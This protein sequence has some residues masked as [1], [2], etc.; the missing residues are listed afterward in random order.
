MDQIDE[1]PRR[2]EQQVKLVAQVSRRSHPRPDRLERGGVPANGGW[3]PKS[4][5]GSSARLPR[6]NCPRA[7]PV[8]HLELTGGG[9]TGSCL[10]GLIRQ[11]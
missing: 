1:P 6:K 4:S 2:E 3:P 5:K 9:R 7:A 11:C 8:F 10:Q